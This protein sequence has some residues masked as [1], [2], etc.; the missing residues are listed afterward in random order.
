MFFIINTVPMCIFYPREINLKSYFL[1]IQHIVSLVIN[2]L[3]N[4]FRFKNCNINVGDF[5]LELKQKLKF[6]IRNKIK[7]PN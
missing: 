2:I 4:T 3:T 5:Y 1:Y 7:N 6:E